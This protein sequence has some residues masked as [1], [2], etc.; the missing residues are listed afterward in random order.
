M[1]IKFVNLKK[2]W[3]KE[4]KDLLKIIDRTINSGDWVGGKNIQLFEKKISKICNTKYAVALNSG[5]DA[6]TLA[7]FSLGV[8][9]GDEVITTSNSFVASVSAIVHLGAKPVFVDVLPDQTMDPSL[10]EKKI[11]KKTKAIMP[12]HLTGRVSEMNEINRIAKKYNIP[13]VEDAAQSIG[14]KYYNK[15]TGSLGK[16]GCFSAHPLKNLNAIGDGGYLT[17]NDKKIFKKVIEL[18]NHGMIDRNKIKNFGHV[19]RL[20]NLQAAVLNFRLKKLQKVIEKRRKNFKLYKKFLNRDFV[21]F[22][23][24]KKYQFNTYHTFVVQVNKRD[25][26]IK[27]LKKNKIST[28]IH[29]PIPI[30]LQPAAKYLKYK[31]G[32]LKN[33]EKQSKKILT[34]PINQ[35]LKDSE[36]KFI[37]KKI[38]LF[39]KQNQK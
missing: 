27:F 13:V 23:D 22:P 32:S 29:Y 37:S 15:P 5:T 33:T 39:F 3:N 30:H 35:Y 17:T 8:K 19:S 14:S 25:S 4:R 1:K 31:K 26:L 7:L 24:E 20:D 11:T 16:V 18:R 2:Q 6:L 21:F 10:L 36:I 34:L 38:N 12:V 9:K 28:A